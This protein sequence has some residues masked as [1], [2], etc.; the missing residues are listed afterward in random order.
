MEPKQMA[1]ELLQGQLELW[2]H[3]LGYVKPVALKCAMDLGIADAIVRCGGTATLPELLATTELPPCNLPYLRRIMRVLTFSRIFA[4]ASGGDGDEAVYK[5]TAASRLLVGKVDAAFCQSRCVRALVNLASGSPML[6]MHP[7]I[8]DERAAAASMFQK[9]HGVGQGQCLWKT[10][11]RT[12]MGEGFYKTM[13][14][15]S[16]L[17]M[18]AV[19]TLSP[20]V[21]QGAASLVDVGGAYGAAAAAV[22]MAFPHMECTVLD[23]PHVVAEAPAP[24]DA[25]GVRFVA[26]DMFQHIPPADVVLLKV[27]SVLI[28]PVEF[29]A[30][31]YIVLY[32]FTT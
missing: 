7:W 20:A 23:L 17:F 19:L 31:T 1:E 21:F 13:A 12:A 16:S 10:T 30:H 24:A 14:A 27:Q 9:A 28:L 6:N 3:A 8:T 18:H 11:K 26:G 29:V 25:A 32:M 22:A 15:D 5:L 4:P 2:H